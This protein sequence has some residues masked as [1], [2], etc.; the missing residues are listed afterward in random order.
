MRLVLLCIWIALIAGL[1][2]VCVAQIAPNGAGFDPTPVEIP[3]ISDA[4]RRPITSMDLL[5]IRDLHGVQISPDGKYVAFVVGQAVLENNSYRTGLF[6]ISTTG[7]NKPFSLGTAGPQHWDEINQSVD[8]PPQWSRDSR[9]LYYRMN[10][11]G[12][13][14]VWRWALTG[15]APVQ[16]THVEHDVKDFQLTP[17]GGQLVLTVDQP[18][19]TQAELQEISQHGVLYDDDLRAWLSRPFLEEFVELKLRE[20][21]IWIHDLESTQE[22]KAT[23]AEL[24]KL[25]RWESDLPEKQFNSRRPL[26]GHRIVSSKI[27][28]DGESVAFVEY[29]DDPA[30]GSQDSRELFSKPARDGKPI[31]LTPGAFVLDTYWWSPDSNQIYYTETGRDGH[32]RRLMVVPTHGGKARRVMRPPDGDWLDSFSTDT[33]VRLVACTRETNNTPAQVELVNV[34]TGEFRLLVDLN[35]EFRNLQVSKSW[36]IDVTNKY[37]DAFRGHVVLPLN[38]EEGKRYPLVIVTYTDG[39]EFLRGGVGDEY[40]IQVFAANG[41]VVLQ[42]NDS[43]SRTFKPGDFDAAIL[44]W[45]S[46]VEGMK[47]MVEKLAAMSIIDPKRAGLTGLSHGSDLVNYAISH[48]D[49]VRAAI[50]SSAIGWDP[51]HYYI[52]NRMVRQWMTNWGLGGWPEGKSSTKWRKIS[53]VLNA[54]RIEAP[55]LVNVADTEYLAGLAHLGAAR[56]LAKP[57][58]MFVYPNESHVK[59][60][61]KHRYEIY[62]RNVDWFKFWFQS[63]EDSD[64]AKTE[65]YDRWHKLREL[66]EQ[67]MKKQ[68]ATQTVGSGE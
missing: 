31:A 20:P 33:E 9:S 19:F 4:P 68:T 12:T 1:V 39:D 60:Q 30:H 61:P 37:G 21:L 38:Y 23:D 57:I 10:R 53:T 56:A 27:S 16:V 14:Q 42:F 47:V 5:M 11:S 35:P 65:Q 66:H 58:E 40:P 22:R 48:S 7:T 6:V 13:W 2:P 55:L 52:A 29:L 34:S 3:A 54:D 62:E 51:Y 25:G 50:A 26:E 17:D 24:K 28:P 49:F 59:N 46:P 45:E 43:Y 18:A 64:P 63:K 15:D 41:F 67:D 44:Q 36:R 8:D 32:S